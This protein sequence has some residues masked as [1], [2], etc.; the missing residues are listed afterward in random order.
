MLTIMRTTLL[1]LS[2]CLLLISCGTDNATTT[3]K[4][5][6]LA[7]AAEEAVQEEATP[8]PVSTQ[9]ETMDD[10]AMEAVMAEYEQ[11]ARGQAVAKKSG[12]PGVICSGWRV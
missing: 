5:D 12:T 2:T 6:S 3:T 8:E 10:N 1:A 9:T 7:A 11:Q 4:E